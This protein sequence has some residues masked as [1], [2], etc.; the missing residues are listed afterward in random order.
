MVF[1]YCQ[2]DLLTKRVY[3]AITLSRKHVVSLC[4]YCTLLTNFVQIPLNIFH[5]IGLCLCK[6]LV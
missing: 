5:L 1:N 4:V 2:D 6:A 3:F